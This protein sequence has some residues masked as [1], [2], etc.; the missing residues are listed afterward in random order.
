[1]KAYHEQI[2]EYLDLG[3]IETANPKFEGTYTYLPHHPV[4]R[5]DKATTKVRPVFNGASKPKGGL[6]VNDCLHAGPNLNPELLAVLLRFRTFNFAWISD[7]EK[8]FLQIK[9]NNEDS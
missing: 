8:A 6:S 1:M 2:R 9:L 7:I 3:F 5:N 4:V